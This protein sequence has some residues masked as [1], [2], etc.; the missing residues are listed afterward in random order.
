MMHWLILAVA[1]VA[2]VIA[3]SG[4]KTGTFYYSDYSARQ[5]SIVSGPVVR[6]APAL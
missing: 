1:I 3:T 2:E 4:E 5:P 6:E